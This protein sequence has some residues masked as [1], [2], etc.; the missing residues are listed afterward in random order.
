MTR[1][2]PAEYETHVVRPL[3]G[4]AQLPDDL[5]ARYAIDLGMHDAQVADRIRQV[6]AYWAKKA[7]FDTNAGMV[8]KAFIRAH[9]KLEAEH[10]DQLNTVRWWQQWHEQRSPEIDQLVPTPGAPSDD[11]PEVDGPSAVVDPVDAVKQ[12]LVDG[13]LM[14]AQKASAAFNGEDAVTAAEFVREQTERVAQLR[15]AANADL[16]AG[17]EER[18]ALQLRQAVELASDL[19]EL[20][21]ELAR[22]PLAPVLG[23]TAQPEG[24]GVRLGWRASPSH[25]EST[26]YRVVRRTGRPPAS[27]TDGQI[28]ANT[29]TLALDDPAPPVGCA[30]F[31]AVF[32]GPGVEVW[33]RPAVEEISVVPPVSHLQATGERD[34]I[35]LEWQA[36]PEV[37][38]VRVWRKIGFAAQEHG[39]PLEVA[40]SS[41]RDTEV[42]DGVEYVYSV[43]A[44]YRC[45]DRDDEITAAP[46]LVRA[47][48]RPDLAAVTELRVHSVGTATDLRV[49]V[50]WRQPIG[51]EVVLRRDVRAPSW[52]V[53]ERVSTSEIASYGRELS[54]APILQDGW[55]TLTATVPAGPSVYVPFTIDRY[56]GIRGRE[57]A[58]GLAQ[59]VRQLRG[60]RFGST[61]LLSWGWPD[62]VT[63]AEVGWPGGSRRITRQ[64]YDDEGGCHIPLSSQAAGIEVLTVVR[65]TNQEARSTP[66]TIQISGEQPRLS[67]TLQ[68]RGSRLTGGVRCVVV[69]LASSQYVQ[70][71]VLVVVAEGHNMPL[72]AAEG[73]VLDERYESIVPGVEQ[74]WEVRL[75]RLRRPYWVRCFVADDDKVQ[76]KVQLVDPP[77][78]QLKVS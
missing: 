74:V 44:V 22:L 15:T 19:P 56:G 5:I 21:A 48:T 23:L 37:V 61:V 43:V 64:Q 12:L 59:P 13:K 36:H 75:P 17:R 41:I 47:A 8:C 14:A 58:F 26:Q 39:K 69:R 52:P 63:V 9:T 57:A 27:P 42:E 24:S 49:Q 72:T 54:G 18:A 67:Y 33:S 66:A 4:L 55:M 73:R 1:F 34:A 35:I 65:A 11:T 20:A 6:R 40:N 29:S 38:A 32:A 50:A 25:G 3:R 71:T 78:S 45:A 7:R 51:A 62:E 77:L 31:Y 60:E 16:A 30:V 76:D 70:C 53:G 2:D 68:R 10:G 28:I 46:A